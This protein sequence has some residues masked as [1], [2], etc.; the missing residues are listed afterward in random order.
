MTYSS[1]FLINIFLKLPC[2]A[3]RRNPL[4]NDFRVGVFYLFQ[5]GVLRLCLP[6]PNNIRKP[7][8]Q[9]F[10]T[11]NADVFVFPESITGTL[12]L[13]PLLNQSI[14]LDWFVLLEERSEK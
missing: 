4:R 12:R 14:E 9:R 10:T 13:D 11:V 1:Q 5:R 8:C 7:V 3:V 2:V 6:L